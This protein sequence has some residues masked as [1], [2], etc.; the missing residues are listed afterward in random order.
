MHMNMKHRLAGSFIDVNSDIISVGV[1]TLV[2][3]LLHILEHHIHRFPFMIGQIEV[4][5]D[6][7]LGNYQ[8]MSGRNRVTVIESHARGR[9]TNHLHPA[10]QTAKGTLFPF[11]PWKFIE[12]IVLVKL[13]TRIAI[14]TQKR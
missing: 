14:Q 4:G 2:H 1:I 9:L 13:I 5:G 10:R 6:M 7:T 11:L 12:M 8:G 3:L